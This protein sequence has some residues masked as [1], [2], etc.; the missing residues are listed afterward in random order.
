MLIEFKIKF[1]LQFRRFFA[2]GQWSVILTYTKMSEQCFSRRFIGVLL[3]F[4]RHQKMTFNTGIYRQ[5]KILCEFVWPYF[6][7]HSH[8]TKCEIWPKLTFST[9]IHFIPG[10]M[11]PEIR[12][13]YSKRMFSCRYI[14]VLKVNIWFLKL[15]RINRLAKHPF[16]M[17][18]PV[19]WF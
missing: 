15:S 12:S 4:F 2:N 5:G 14:A 1:N 19:V 17:N 9:L 18:Y 3:N 6:W 13:K 8:G 11:S 16:F 7:G 10:S